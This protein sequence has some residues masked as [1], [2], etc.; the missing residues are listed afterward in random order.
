MCCFRSCTHGTRPTWIPPINP[1][2]MNRRSKRNG[3]PLHPQREIAFHK[4]SWHEHSNAHAT[5]TAM[6][7]VGTPRLCVDSIPDELKDR[8]HWV[9]WRYEQRENRSTKVPLDVHT[10]RR[11]SSTDPATW[12]S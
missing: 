12:A 1:T 8:P 6:S 10:G 11:A 3:D 7:T 5:G 4:E 2:R 9:A